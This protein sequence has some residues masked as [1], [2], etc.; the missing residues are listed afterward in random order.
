MN[1]CGARDEVR[2]SGTK[3]ILRAEPLGHPTVKYFEGNL[4]FVFGGGIL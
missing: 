2:V 1:C 3:K 4:V